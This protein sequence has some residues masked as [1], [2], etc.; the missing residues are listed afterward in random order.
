[1]RNGKKKA[2]RCQR[3]TDEYV[4]WCCY[5]SYSALANKLVQRAEHRIKDGS[6]NQAHNFH[7]VSYLF[8]AVLVVYY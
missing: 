1:M 2:D 5:T 8:I 7:F 3:V 4:Q 6:K